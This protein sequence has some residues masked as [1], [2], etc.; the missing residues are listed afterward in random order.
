MLEAAIQSKKHI[1]CEKPIG[2]DVEGV[3]R[4]MAASKKADKTKTIAV[5]FQQRYG[6]EYLEAYK[7]VKSGEIGELASARAAWIANDPFTR[8]P[9]SDARGREAA[10]LVLLQ[11]ILG[12]HHRGAGLPQS[13]RPALVPRRLCRFRRSAAGTRRSAR[14]WTSS[15]TS[16]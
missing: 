1:Y 3:K 15:T 11:G 13:G 7:R 6:K 8:R 2:V 16:R 12:R 10:E 4:A 9:F 5:G 14:T